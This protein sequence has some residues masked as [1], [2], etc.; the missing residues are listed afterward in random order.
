V[1]DFKGIGVIID[2]HMGLYGILDDGWRG[3]AY[4]RRMETGGTCRPSKGS[5]CNYLFIYQFRNVYYKWGSAAI[6]W[7]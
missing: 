4:V 2:S 7:V 1:S 3:S 6:N 5:E